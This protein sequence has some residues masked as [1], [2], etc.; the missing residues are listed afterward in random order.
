[1]IWAC[2]PNPEV[3]S[4]LQASRTL[5]HHSIYRRTCMTL[6]LGSRSQTRKTAIP[7]YAS[8]RLA[9]SLG[10]FEALRS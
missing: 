2:G 5:D 3:L 10:G 6:V 1:M 4:L 7:H 8:N 9:I